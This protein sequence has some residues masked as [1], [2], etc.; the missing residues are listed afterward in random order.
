MAISFAALQA[1]AAELST[2][3]TALTTQAAA[4]D[5]ASNQ[6][7]LDAVTQTITAANAELAALIVPPAAPAE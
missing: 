5:D 1:A 6:A 4:S 3:A 7:T 2:N